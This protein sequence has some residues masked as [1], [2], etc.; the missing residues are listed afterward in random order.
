MKRAQDRCTIDILSTEQ[1]ILSA[2]NRQSTKQNI[3]PQESR[4]CPAQPSDELPQPRRTVI[5]RIHRKHH[6]TRNCRNFPGRFAHSHGPALRLPHHAALERRNKA[7]IGGQRCAAA[8]YAVPVTLTDLGGALI[9]R[10]RQ[11]QAPCVGSEF[12]SGAQKGVNWI[13]Y[14]CVAYSCGR[15]KRLAGAAHVVAA[16]GL[17]WE[18]GVLAG[19]NRGGRPTDHRRSRTIT[20]SSL[21]TASRGPAASLYM[22]FHPIGVAA[23]ERIFLTACARN[24]PSPT[25]QSP[26]HLGTIPCAKRGVRQAICK[27]LGMNRA[28]TVLEGRAD[29]VVKF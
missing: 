7:A 23:S 5:H 6:E 19:G 25:R 14:E 10:A 9:N 26:L 13:Q 15:G 28:V 1:M 8:G 24:G 3:E 4:K 16:G 17:S 29:G 21:R 20:A 22:W 12:Y 2:R 11:H 18:P 27:R